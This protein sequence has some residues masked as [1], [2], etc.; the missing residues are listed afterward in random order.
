ML[1]ASV[2]TSPATA[3]AY[4]FLL[5]PAIRWRHYLQTLEEDKQ[6]SMWCVVLAMQPLP[7]I[8]RHYRDRGGGSDNLSST[9]QP[10]QPASRYQPTCP[11]WTAAG[12]AAGLN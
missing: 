3:S 8:P 10:L 7:A 6:D 1:C 4:L 12:A 5:P 2:L 9:T 11:I